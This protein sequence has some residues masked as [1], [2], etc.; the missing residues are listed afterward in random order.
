MDLDNN[1][2]YLDNI[3]KVFND[4]NVDY[5]LVGGTAVILHG[6]MRGSHN[7]PRNIE[8][9]YD[10]WYKASLSNFSNLVEALKQIQPA[11]GKELD[12]IVFRPEKA[13]L[14]ITEEPYKIE[15]LP[16]IK[17]FERKDFDIVKSR[18]M[19]KNIKTQ[20]ATVISYKDLITSKEALDRPIDRSD[21]I[22]LN[23]IKNKRK[24]QGFSLWYI[25]GGLRIDFPKLDFHLSLRKTHAMVPNQY[26][27][28]VT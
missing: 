2:G 5:L 18:S 14:R 26:H 21:I 28:L 24:D 10:F 11:A 7:L 3:I 15:L 16:N 8:F 4:N 20:F 19:S 17:G 9:D 25:N 23:K 22:E 1:I 6:H 13:Y 27:F 12:H